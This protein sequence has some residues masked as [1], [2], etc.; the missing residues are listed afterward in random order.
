M[1][2]QGGEE[3]PSREGERGSGYLHVSCSKKKGLGL[4]YKIDVLRAARKKKRRE[5]KGGEKESQAF[6]SDSPLQDSYH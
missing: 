5:G 1:S 2:A 6:A 3:T 4:K